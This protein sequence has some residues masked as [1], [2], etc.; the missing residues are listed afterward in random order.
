MTRVDAKALKASLDRDLLDSDWRA[1]VAQVDGAWRVRVVWGRHRA[2]P[3]PAQTRALDAVLRA[4]QL[5]IHA[6]TRLV[7]PW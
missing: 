3:S 4:R 7:C 5:S 1:E 6:E 2:Q